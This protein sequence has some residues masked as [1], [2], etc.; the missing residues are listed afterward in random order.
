MD[1]THLSEE[2]ASHFEPNESA[3]NGSSN[4]DGYATGQPVANCMES[5]TRELLDLDPSNIQFAWKEV[6]RVIEE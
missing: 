2:Q 4:Y 6:E 3:G 1:C 5:T